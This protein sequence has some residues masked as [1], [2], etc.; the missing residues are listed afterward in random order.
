M[1]SLLLA[2]LQTI[3]VRTAADLLPYWDALVGDGGFRQRT[4]WV[5]VL[6]EDAHPTPVVVPIDD[7]PPVPGHLGTDG[8]RRC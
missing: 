6:D 1:T 5:G 4:L 2:F 8:L 7:V 3:T